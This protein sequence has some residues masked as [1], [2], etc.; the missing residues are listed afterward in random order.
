MKIFRCKKCGNLIVS[1]NGKNTCTCCGEVM[2]ELKANSVDASVEKHVPV[3]S[4]KQQEIHITCGETLHPMEENHYIEFMVMETN[5][6]FQIHYLHPGEEPSSCFSLS[7][8][9]EFVAAYAYCNLHGLWIQ[10]E[11]Q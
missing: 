4:I 6:G 9:E 1:I 8:N 3:V 7:E 11:V 5:F 10:K 2:Q